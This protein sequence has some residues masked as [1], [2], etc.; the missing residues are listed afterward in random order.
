MIITEFLRK[1][2]P[3]F[4][5]CTIKIGA[6]ALGVR[7][8]R[9]IVGE[10]ILNIQDLRSARKFPDV[11]VHNACFVVDIHNPDGG[12]Q[13]EGVAE[14][15]RPYDIPYRCLVPLEIE[16][17]IIAGRCISSTH[18]AQASFRVMSICMAIGEAAGI[19]AA[20]SILNGVT[21]RKLKP[22]IIQQELIK[23]GA[24]LFDEQ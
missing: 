13:Q 24:V 15:V 7:E 23:K 6:S 11:V 8:S 1:Y 5:K 12:G 4:S 2:V 3:G 9:R 18:E 22:G 10:Y 19:A 17:L 20:Q 21:P 14:A 16:N